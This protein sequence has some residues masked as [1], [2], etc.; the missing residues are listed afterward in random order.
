MGLL[1]V[2]RKGRSGRVGHQAASMAG[3]CSGAA[4]LSLGHSAPSC[5]LHTKNRFPGF[6]DVKTFGTGG[7]E[8]PKTLGPL[9]AEPRERFLCW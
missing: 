2:E 9:S 8:D 1:T 4:R 3:V 6:T 5:L 7:V